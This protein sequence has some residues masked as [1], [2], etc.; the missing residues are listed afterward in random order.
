[1]ASITLTIIGCI[2]YLDIGV[3]F[4]RAV[5]LFVA[6]EQKMSLCFPQ[7]KPKIFAGRRWA[8]V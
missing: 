4:T 1:M 3:I 5:F 2:G 6:A 7:K 8:V